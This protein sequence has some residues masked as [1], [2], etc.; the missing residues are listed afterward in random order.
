MPGYSKNSAEYAAM[1]QAAHCRKEVD[2][3]ADSQVQ[4]FSGHDSAPY[5]GGPN[6]ADAVP[7]GGPGTGGG[8]SGS[9]TAKNNSAGR[10]SY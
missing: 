6:Q 8:V 2:F 7:G 5:G 10:N 1:E 9:T 3:D 4:T